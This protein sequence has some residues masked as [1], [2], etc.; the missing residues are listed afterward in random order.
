MNRY[1]RCNTWIKMDMKEKVC[2]IVSVWNI[3]THK[4]V[5]EVNKIEEG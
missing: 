3:V 4:P 1:L 2:V 5:K